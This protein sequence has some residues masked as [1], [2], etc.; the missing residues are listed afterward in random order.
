MRLQATARL[1]QLGEDVPREEPLGLL[2]IGK[3][4]REAVQ[5]DAERRRLLHTDSLRH[6]SA[7]DTA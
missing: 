6:Q 4:A 7:D 2:L 1:G 5:V 3:V